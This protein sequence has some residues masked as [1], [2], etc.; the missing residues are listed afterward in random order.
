MSWMTQFC[1]FQGITSI[2]L[3][4]LSVGMLIY[5][6][7]TLQQATD[8]RKPRQLSSPCTIYNFN[9]NTFYFH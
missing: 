6:S 2:E 5:D 8:P 4:I 1:T 9:S 7:A 3:A